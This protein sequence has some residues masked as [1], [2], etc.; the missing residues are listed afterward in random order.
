MFTLLINFVLM[1]FF[2]NLDWKIRG[3]GE[4]EWEYRGA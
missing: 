1:S 3:K 2:I 4:V